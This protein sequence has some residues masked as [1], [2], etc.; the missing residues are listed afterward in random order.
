MIAALALAAASLPAFAEENALNVFNWSDYIADDTVERFEAE[1][2]IK[3]TY[4]EFD[5]KDT[6]EA[7]LA[8]GRTGLDVVVPTASFLQH[9]TADGMFRKLDKSLLAN[10]GNLDRDLN[11]IASAYDPGNQYAVPYLWGTTGIGYN[12]ARIKERM[13][14]APLDSWR[15]LFEPSVVSRFKDCGVAM[16]DAPVDVIKAVLRFLGRDPSSPRAEDI[17]A[18]E[19]HL[20]RLRPYI[21]YFD[22]GRYIDDLA[23]GAACLV[24]GWSGDVVQARG[25]ARD[26]GAEIEIGYSVPK[27]GAMVWMDVLAI[28]ADAPHPEA[29]HRFIDFILRPEIA[30]DIA[31]TVGF[32]NAN[33]ASL[34]DLDPELKAD[35]ALYPHQAVKQR[36][37]ADKALTPELDRLITAA[38]NRAKTGR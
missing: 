7:R 36:L 37:F 24:L 33:A 19:A 34:G 16:P 31:N 29:A 15:L 32:A 25:R 28:P 22:T 20:A 5:S 6:L 14:N 26:A 27:E 23:S 8:A 13:A 18:A 9:H 10:Y 2:G 17:R 21:A 38:F 4:E 35:Q 30:A 11:R 3:V 12:V 1:T